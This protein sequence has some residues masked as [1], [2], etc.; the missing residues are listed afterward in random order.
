[1]VMKSDKRHHLEELEPRREDNMET[2][3]KESE[4]EVMKCNFFF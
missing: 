4:W 2:Y 1:M 3:L